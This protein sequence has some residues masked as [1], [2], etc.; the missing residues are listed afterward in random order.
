MAY[1]FLAAAA[2]AAAA[3]VDLASAS[4]VVGLRNNYSI[5]EA[6]LQGFD[7]VSSQHWPAV[8]AC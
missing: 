1:S 3:A 2:A 4:A 7:Q 6:D 8:L 5:L